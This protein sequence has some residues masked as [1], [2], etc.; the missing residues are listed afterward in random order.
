MPMPAVLPELIAELAHEPAEKDKAGHI[1]AL[2]AII[3]QIL[4]RVEAQLDAVDEELRRERAH[5]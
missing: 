2:H 1:E 5:R 3:D 4:D